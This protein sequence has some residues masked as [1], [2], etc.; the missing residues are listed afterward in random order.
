MRLY[1][2]ND[3]I[4]VELDALQDSFDAVGEK[5]GRVDNLVGVIHGNE[6]G[7]ARVI[8]LGYKGSVDYGD[9]VV[10]TDYS[11]ED[12]IKL[13]EEL[14]IAFFQ[15]PV[16]DYCGK[17]IYGSFTLGDRGAMCWECDKKNGEK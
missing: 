1:R 17:V 13:C 14:G 7:L 10:H 12:F 4:I 3:K 16:C 9:I 8:D 2:K 11:R 15:Y 5:I 6:Q